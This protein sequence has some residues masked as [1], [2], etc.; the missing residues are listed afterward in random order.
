MALFYSSILLAVGASLFYHVVLKMTPTGVNPAISLVVTYALAMVLSLGLLL[1]FPLKT[2][3]IDA[4]RQLNWTSYAL[5]LALVG[6]EAGFLLA[7]RAGWNVSLAA[8]VVNVAATMLLVVL[9]IW[10][11]HEK[12]TVANLAG[13][14]LCIAGL[15][16]V[17]L[18]S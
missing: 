17:N 16:L 4:F 15:V 3:I 9:G 6:L 5:A 7:Y 10:L 14:L 1:F 8:I 13:I 2:G 18:K 11:F 12:L